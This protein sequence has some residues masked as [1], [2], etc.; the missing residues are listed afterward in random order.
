[1]LYAL[2]ALCSLLTALCSL[3]PWGSLER[4]RAYTVRYSVACLL[5]LA[6]ATRK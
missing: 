3:R 6:L 1:M 2:L 4:A 5:I